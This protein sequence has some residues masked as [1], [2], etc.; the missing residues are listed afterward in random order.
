[1]S[2]AISPDNHWLVTIG[3]NENIIRLW[4]LTTPHLD[5]ASGILR[6]HEG[7]ISTVTISLDSRWL[8]TD[9]YD[10]KIA[11]LWDLTTPDVTAASVVLRGHEGKIPPKEPQ[12]HYILIIQKMFFQEGLLIL[13][14]HVL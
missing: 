2:M 4:D 8:I 5:A 13:K 7:K 1:M 12:L 9:S 14:L 10:E 11:R 6:G 3:E